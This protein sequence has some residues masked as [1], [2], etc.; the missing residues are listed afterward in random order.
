MNGPRT[1]REYYQFRDHLY[2]LDGVIMYKER[3]VIPP[4]LRDDC[5]QALHSAH[6]GASMMTARA[7]SSVFWPGNTKAITNTTA[8]CSY[9][10]RMAP[11]QS[12]APPMPRLEP[13]YPFQCMCVDYFQYKGSNYLVVVDRYSIWPIV[14]SASNGAAGLISCLRRI[15]AT[16]GIADEITS[17]GGPEFTAATT[18]DFLRQ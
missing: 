12:S 14:E 18:G 10:N 6:Q 2:T 17:D 13:A 16:Y 9:C 8:G 4:T 3:V 5:I 11:S 7:E 1:L 15:F